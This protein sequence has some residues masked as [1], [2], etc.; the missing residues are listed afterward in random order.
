MEFEQSSS[1]TLAIVSLIFSD[2][3]RHAYAER[4][5]HWSQ[6][7]TGMSVGMDALH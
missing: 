1:G 3:T 4:S 5:R 6:H 2:K 7:Y